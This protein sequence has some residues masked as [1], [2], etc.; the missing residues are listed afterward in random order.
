MK[1]VIFKVKTI[2]EMIS[3]RLGYSKVRARSH[4]A[5]PVSSPA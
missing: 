4:A 3:E 5:L 1:R 2:A